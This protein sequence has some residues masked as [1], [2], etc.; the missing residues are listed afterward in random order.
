MLILKMIRA[1]VGGRTVAGADASPH[2][3]TIVSY[4][5]QH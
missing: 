4:L 5:E 2:G 3:Y 1:D